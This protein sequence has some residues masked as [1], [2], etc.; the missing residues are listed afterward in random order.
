MA[1]ANDVVVAGCETSPRAPLH[2]GGLAPVLATDGSTP[3]STP[4]HPSK[5]ARK[6]LPRD[7]QLIMSPQ[8]QQQSQ[9]QQQQS[10]H[11]AGSIVHHDQ[12]H[13]STSGATSTSAKKTARWLD[14]LCDEVLQ[15][16]ESLAPRPDEAAARQAAVDTVTSLALNALPR[17]SAQGMRIAVFGSGACGLAMHS[18][19]VDI[20]LEGVA[21]PN[22]DTGHFDSADRAIALRCLRAIERAACYGAPG[23]RALDVRGSFLI[24]RA[25]IPVLKLTL[26]SGLQLDISVNDGGGRRA[27]AFLK[28]MVCLCLS[29]YAWPVYIEC[30]D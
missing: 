14:D 4:R 7:E 27:A 6:Q 21:R 28:S 17:E 5:K 24:G 15:L 2:V 29:L 8:Q 26:R 11:A 25:R 19:D 18:S 3:P 9:Q 30:V 13:K 23:R 1:A 22:P 12:A 10:Q 16:A 20:V